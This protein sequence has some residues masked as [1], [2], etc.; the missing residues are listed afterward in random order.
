MS[1]LGFSSKSP[2]ILLVKLEN[3][4]KVEENI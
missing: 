2:I 1:I 3:L 4:G